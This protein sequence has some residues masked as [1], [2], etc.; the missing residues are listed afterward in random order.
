[1]ATRLPGL[2]LAPCRAVLS[3]L[4]VALVVAGSCG[5]LSL[6]LPLLPALGS[7]AEVQAMNVTSPP[8]CRLFCPGS[9]VGIRICLQHAADQ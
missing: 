4:L 8:Q 2:L 5:Q 6:V 9:E 7:S 1:M 3:W